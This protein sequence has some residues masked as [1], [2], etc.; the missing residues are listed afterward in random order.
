MSPPIALPRPAGRWSARHLPVV[1]LS[2]SLLLALSAVGSPAQTPYKVVSPD[3]KV[4]YTDR[5]VA[6]Q[7]G[8]QVQALK[9]DAISGSAAGPPLPAELRAVQARFPV[10]LYT[11]AECASCD[12]GRRLLQLRGVPYNERLVAS[13]DDVT[14]LQRL[15][16]G[17]TL[18]VLTVAGQTL[19]GFSEN[20]WLSTLDLA[21]Y[22]KESRLPRGWQ[23]PA[24][25]P[26]VARAPAVVPR[27]ADETRAPSEPAFPQAASDPS[28]I[29]F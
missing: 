18:P 28:G 25:E 1:R 4:T 22:P 14:A 20:D 27:A 5:P 6:V 21:G 12:S 15:S 7:P 17:R 16:G 2:A 29:R 10:M 13:E 8:M 9:R 11:T 19:R 24:A 3:G 23:A 26:L